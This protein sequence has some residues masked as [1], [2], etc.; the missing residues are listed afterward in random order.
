MT[1]LS[2][3]S[4][5]LRLVCS[6]DAAGRSH[7]SAQSFAAPVH[8]SKPFTEAGALVLNVMTPTAGFLEGD[9]T[10]ISARVEAGARLILSTPAAGRVHQMRGGE[11]T[12]RQHFA[13][14]AGAFLE[15]APELLIPQKGG[16]YRQKTRIDLAPGASL[17][18]AEMLA[19]GRV[20]AGEVLEFERLDWETEIYQDGILR[21]RER[22]AV[23]PQAA[24]WPAVRRMFAT[25]Y[26]A[27]C[28]AF[29]G[30]AAW[31]EAVLALQEPGQLWAGAGP[32]EGGGAIGRLLAGEAPTLRRGLASM[33]SSFYEFIDRP[34]PDLRR[35]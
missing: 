29:P 4:G 10:E 2:G 17:F 33:R 6:L 8:I 35:R 7:L 24:I 23:T 26:F 16:R 9:H 25:P 18:F 21:A 31:I 27:T 30:E 11:A 5:H 13:V 1:A 28:F 34:L 22:F 32:L 12:V 20:A 19:P 3:L 14:E 15:A